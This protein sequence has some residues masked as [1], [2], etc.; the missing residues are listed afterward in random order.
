MTA[1][2]PDLAAGDA[3][4]PAR[5]KGLAARRQVALICAALL[6]L[7]VASVAASSWLLREHEISDWRLD[8][9]NLS[10]VLAESV[11]QT[12][13]SGHLM[14]DS[15]G[16]LA[17]SNADDITSMAVY[18][19]MRD[20]AAMLPQI[21]VA[22][23]VDSAGK[24]RASTLGY[25]A[26][27][28]N[29]AERDYFRYH[30]S[31]AVGQPFLGAPE[32]AVDGRWIFY[33]SQRLDDSRGQFAG[34]VVV[35]VSCDYLS[36]S[37]RTASLDGKATITLYRQDLTLLARWPQLADGGARLH[38]DSA[39]YQVLSSGKRH[40]V[41]H[42]PHRHTGGDEPAG[43]LSAVRMVR[44]YP[45]VLTASVNEDTLL[46]GWQTSMRLIS[47]VALASAV[48]M[49]AAFWLVARLLSRRESD[50]LEA[51]A[52]QVRADE[53]SAAKSRLLAM[54]SHEIR[55]PMNAILGMSELLLDTDLNPIQRSY[56]GNVHQ[57][58]SQLLHIINDALDF[59][60]I[61]SGHMTINRQPYDPAQLVAQ[62]VALHRAGAER[63]GL[64]I[65]CR[66]SAPPGQIEGDAARLRQV[67]SNLLDN[68]IKFTD[69]GDIELSFS[70]LPNGDRWLLRYAVRD[71][72][73]GITAVT[74]G[75][76]FEPFC[77]REYGATH[78]GTGLGLAVCQRLVKLMGGVISCTSELGAGSTFSLEI[79]SRYLMMPAPP[80]ATSPAPPPVPAP[81]L[82]VGGKRVLLVEDSEMN[83]QLARILLKK[84]GWEVDEAHDG[85]QA[86]AA[87]A[88][89]SYDIVLMDCMMPV[90]DG[91]EATRRY[92]QWEL[93]EG[94]TRTPVVALTAS[95][96]E[97]DRERCLAAGADDYLSKPF[98]A[99]AFSGVLARWLGSNDT[100]KQ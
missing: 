28:A 22:H 26:P 80:L 57:G 6:T 100:V 62:V 56:A 43:S 65:S 98:T 34:V 30:R 18:R 90:M 76:L 81:A 31:H 33:L 58:T 10:Q 13:S 20:Q 70:A 74:L 77:Q 92:R 99:A 21:A 47:V 67:L 96:I 72:G 60:K 3:P 93:D 59:S 66:C 61:E 55:T 19:S 84:L 15:L 8:L 23:I 24:V 9:G 85:Q 38:L 40:D 97:G 17:N 12:L 45:V 52:L 42:A 88:S 46:S 63:K 7:L 83:R 53:A 69:R 89:A 82:P 79:P 44:D 5:L 95:A 50:A 78:G 68:A 51:L 32:R 71:S 25:P 86:L 29:V 41:V 94:R 54:M 75:Q 27:P 87:L 36:E 1:L 48:A 64:H 2:P 39:A 11:A 73:I 4:Q 91:Y 16:G 49:L 37:F 35:G 14:L